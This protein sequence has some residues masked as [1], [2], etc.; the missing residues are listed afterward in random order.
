M[1]GARIIPALLAALALLPG[2][3]MAPQVTAVS[4]NAGTPTAE[5]TPVKVLVELDNPNDAPIELTVWNYSFVVDDRTAYSGEW[6]A[7]LTLP[8]K[9]TME[10][11]LPAFVP[12]SFGE[13]ASKPWKVGGALDYR[14]TGKL[15]KL[16]YQL[17]VNRLSTGFGSTGSGIAPKPAGPPPAPPAAIA[18]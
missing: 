12:A 17:G 3:A 5:G 2:C 14:A 15:D 9:S 4:A 13:L 10:A 18:R 16:L 1:R 6:V 11:E 8:P 7:S